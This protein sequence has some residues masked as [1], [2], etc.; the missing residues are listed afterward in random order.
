M[1]SKIALFAAASM[2]LL[3]AA[4]PTPGGSGDMSN[5]CNTGP[6]QCCN[7]MFD[8]NTEQ[9][10]FL[11]ALVGAVVGPITGQI[12]ANCSPISAIGI[13][14]NSCTQQPVCCANNDFNGL[15][16]IGCTPINVNL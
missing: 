6:V 9:A 1:F 13:A 5:S 12:G 15:V 10:N 14:G 2:A 7:Q 16:N 8:S 4:A 3:V 11:L